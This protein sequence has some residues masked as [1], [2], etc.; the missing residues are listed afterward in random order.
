[1]EGMILPLIA[2]TYNLWLKVKMETSCNSS[3]GDE[4]G[5]TCCTYVRRAIFSF[6]TALHN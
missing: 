1:M 3:V 6:K 2:G 5:S 4:A